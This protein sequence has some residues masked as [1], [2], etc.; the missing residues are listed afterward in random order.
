MDLRKWFADAGASDMELTLGYPTINAYGVDYGQ[1][2]QLLQ[3]QLSDIGVTLELAPDTFAVMIDKFR[4]QQYS[5]NLLY[6]AP[7]YFGS[8]KYVS[9]FGLVEGA[10]A[11]KNAGGSDDTPLIDP[12]TTEAY[13]AAL[14]TSD[15]AERAV[16]YGITATQMLD[17][18]IIIPLM[19]PDLVLAY[20][21]DVN[22]V[23]YSA[24]CNIVLDQI[25]RD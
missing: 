6:W 1:L 23:G 20:R 14:A 19:S 7:D 25:S 10:R 22:G 21:S 4:T 5:S 9:Y 13:A 3:Q 16:Q 12:V 2:A 15:P 8:S 11:A 24:C 18:N 17:Q